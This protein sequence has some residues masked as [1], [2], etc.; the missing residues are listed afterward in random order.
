ME[1]LRVIV[2]GKF[3]P[4][5]NYLENKSVSKRDLSVD[6]LPDFLALLKKRSEI[7]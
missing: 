4:G 3:S 2:R 1:M 6:M 5:L 7:K